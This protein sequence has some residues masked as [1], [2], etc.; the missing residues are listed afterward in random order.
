[1]KWAWREALSNPCR[2]V[3]RSV[4]SRAVLGLDF[5]AFAY[6]P[7][8]AHLALEAGAGEKQCRNRLATS[9]G[10]VPSR[11]GRA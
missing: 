3:L 5:F 9:T 11:R 10:R 6:D 1:M 4:S 8:E 2:W 7:L